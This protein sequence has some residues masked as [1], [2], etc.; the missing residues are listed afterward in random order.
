MRR[1]DCGR[2]GRKSVEDFIFEGMENLPAESKVD[3][4]ERVFEL[5]EQNDIRE[6]VKSIVLNTLNNV[7]REL[8]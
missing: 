4:A 2:R 7:K 1:K 6:E 3:F 8:V 5:I